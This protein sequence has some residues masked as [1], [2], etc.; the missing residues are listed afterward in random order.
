[1]QRL[2][3]IVR[4]FVDVIDADDPDALPGFLDRQGLVSKSVKAM[5]VEG[6]GDEI[7][8]GPMIVI[9]E[10]G[11]NLRFENLGSGQLLKNLGTGFGVARAF[12]SVALKVRSRDEVAGE[13]GEIGFECAR[14][15]NRPFDLS[16]ADIGPKVEIT[17][18]GDS[19]AVKCFRKAR[20]RD[21]NVLSN[22]NMRLNQKAVY[23]CGRTQSDGPEKSLLKKMSTIQVQ[24]Q[25]LKDKLDTVPAYI[26]R[27][28]WLPQG[29]A[30]NL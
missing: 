14:D 8:V 19:K 2:L 24:V 20:K 15:A 7:R 13:D 22:G 21:G 9:A 18:L 30:M 1:M 4:S 25:F 26:I 11:D 5:A 28:A 3:Q 16:F 29:A 27:G 23:G 17:K 6:F 10:D 12:K